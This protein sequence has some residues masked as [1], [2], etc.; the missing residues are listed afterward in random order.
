MKYHVDDELFYNFVHAS[1]K[2]KW[3]KPTAMYQVMQDYHEDMEWYVKL[4]LD[5]LDGKVI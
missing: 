1:Q 2:Y 5:I 3:D 4:W